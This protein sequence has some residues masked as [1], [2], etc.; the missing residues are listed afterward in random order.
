M[1]VSV[2]SQNL[3]FCNGVIGNPDPGLRQ[4]HTCNGVT[5]NPG[6]GL[7]QAHTCN[8]VTG[9]PDPGLRRQDLDFQ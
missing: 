4:A 9:N 3:D 2:S 6:P 1:Y 7:R 5:G 8:G